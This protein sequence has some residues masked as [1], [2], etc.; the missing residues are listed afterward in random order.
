MRLDD[1]SINENTVQSI[2]ERHENANS[3]ALEATLRKKLKVWAKL[4]SYLHRQYYF[5]TN[6]QLN[7]R[8]KELDGKAVIAGKNKEGLLGLVA[9]YERKQKRRNTMLDN[10]EDVSEDD[11]GPVLLNVFQASFMKPLRKK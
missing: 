2:I 5:Y 8:V 11:V 1:G 3:Q 9:D 4:P 6:A 10:N 7:A